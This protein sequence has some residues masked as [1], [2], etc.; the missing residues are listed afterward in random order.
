M[1]RVQL[2][3]GIVRQVYRVS[4]IDR[5]DLVDSLTQAIAH[6]FRLE[7]P[8]TSV[9]QAMTT[10]PVAYRFYEEGLRAYLQADFAASARLMRAALDEDSTF[11]MAAYYEVLLAGG[12]PL[13]D[14][15]DIAVAR[16][17]AVRLAARAPE[18]ERLTITATLFHQ[19]MDPRASAV[20]ESLATKYPLDP[21]ALATVAQVGR[22]L[23]TGRERSKPSSGPSPSTPWPNRPR[24]PIAVCQDLGQLAD[25]YL[26]WDSLPAA[27]RT[28]RRLLRVRPD[29]AGTHWLMAVVRARL[30]DSTSA[31]MV[32]QFRSRGAGDATWKFHIDL[33]LENYEALESDVR[34]F[35]ASSFKTDWDNAAW[36]YIIGLRN[37]GRLREAWQLHRTDLILGL[38]APVVPRTPDDFNEGIL[39]FERGHGRE[40]AAVFAR[41]LRID[42]PQ[43][44]PGFRARHRAWNGAL[45]G[46]GLAIAGDTGALQVLADSV[47]RWGTGSNYGRDRKAHHYLRGLRLAAAD[48]HE[49]AARE[50]QAAIHSPSLGFTRVNLE[51]ARCLL[52]L[53]RPLEA[54]TTLGGPRCTVP[55]T[56]PTCTSRAPNCTSSRPGVRSRRHGRQCRETLPGRGEG[57]HRADPE[58]LPRR[59]TAQNWLAPAHPR[60]SAA[61]R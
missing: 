15:R 20:A 46:I 30:G 48:R 41:R 44:A 8:A 34:P 39:A 59:N 16:R 60:A 29:E 11:A 18:R 22:A 49:E 26:W 55:P 61:S 58:F 7:S 19:D 28:G 6:Q 21:R 33:M 10:S 25:V 5:T 53:A 32:R 50:Y 27:E 4:A 37:Q 17:H 51:L 42:E 45:E 3:T 38:P 57:R 13:P 2:R 47:E 31:L 40:S 56:R 9:A 36:A 14:G 54:V 52:R 23:G 1:R 43:W 12:R 24:K 35:L